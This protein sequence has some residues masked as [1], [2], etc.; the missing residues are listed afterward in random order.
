MTEKAAQLL[1]RLNQLV[2]ET[3]AERISRSVQDV[4]P[5]AERMRLC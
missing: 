4:P 3:K 2:P 5:G 1:D